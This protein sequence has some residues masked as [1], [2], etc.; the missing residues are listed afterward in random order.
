[1]YWEKAIRRALYEPLD[2]G[3]IADFMAYMRFFN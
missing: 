2:K 1:L 3:K